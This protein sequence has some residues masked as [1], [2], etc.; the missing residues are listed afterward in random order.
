MDNLNL[1]ISDKKKNLYNTNYSYRNN[2]YFTNSFYSGGY[3]FNMKLKPKMNTNKYLNTSNISNCSTN[4]NLTNI[5][6]K[7]ERVLRRT[8]SAL[9]IASYGSSKKNTDYSTYDNS[10]ITDVSNLN[11]SRLQLDKLKSAYY[12][13]IESDRQRS[14][15]KE[16]LNEQENKENEYNNKDYYSSRNTSRYNYNQYIISKKNYYDNKRNISLK[17]PVDMKRDSFL[18]DSTNC[19]YIDNFSY[20][21]NQYGK[22]QTRESTI[23]RGKETHST[24]VNTYEESGGKKME[25]VEE[26]HLQFVKMI[27]S[28]KREFA[29]Q[30]EFLCD[31]S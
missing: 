30:E 11:A 29:K 5:K 31:Y 13:N 21:S 16:L 22:S 25:S 6:I 15:S 17:Y 19:S 18:K 14:N 8:N 20:S 10:H 28:C 9:N 7:T 27:Q 3:H 4:S 26:M 23:G 24:L 1:N 2:D 12:T